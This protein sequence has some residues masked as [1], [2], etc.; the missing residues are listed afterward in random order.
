MEKSEGA[1]RTKP[2]SKVLIDEER[3]GPLG[4]LSGRYSNAVTALC[5]LIHTRGPDGVENQT[6]CWKKGFRSRLSQNLN[7][8]LG[9]PSFFQNGPKVWLY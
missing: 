5:V 3:A 2:T 7:L 9:M 8:Y 4:Y 1:T 6:R